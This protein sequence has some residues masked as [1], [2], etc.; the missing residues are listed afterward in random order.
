MGWLETVV[1]PASVFFCRATQQTFLRLIT[2]AAVVGSY[3]YQPKTNHQA[4]SEYEALF[5]DS[6]IRFQEREPV[7]LEAYW[8]Q[9]CSRGS[10][11]PKL[12]MDAYLAAFAV[13]GGYRMVTVDA[14][15][16]HFDGLDLILPGAGSGK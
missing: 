8:R 16:A 6:R 7:G 12:W 15:F 3:G 11:S 5:V 4:W 2:T 13:A 1:E 9:F 10:A 14:A